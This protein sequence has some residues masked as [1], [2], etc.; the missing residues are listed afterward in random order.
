MEYSR[1]ARDRRPQG[2]D[3]R[4]GPPLSG[5]GLACCYTGCMVPLHIL[6]LIATP[7]PAPSILVLQP[8][9]EPAGEGVSR[10]VPIYIGAPEALALT[11]ALEEQRFARPTTHDLLLDT[12]ASLDATIDHVLVNDVKNGVFYARLTLSQHG[13]LIDL[14][15]RPSDAITLA[16]RHGA[17][18]YIDED[19]LD[20]ASY[21]YLFK[22]P[23]DEEA[24]IGD[25]HDFLEGISPEDFEV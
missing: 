1:S 5:R 9:E 3:L 2:T 25:F 8:D 6:T 23:I 22:Q 13:R 18:L 7:A 10:I 24:V 14:D 15:A 4:A 17:P 19:V 11:S 12:I 20:R 16:V 21:P